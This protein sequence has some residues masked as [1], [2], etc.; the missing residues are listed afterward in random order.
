MSCAFVLSSQR[1]GS[2]LLRLILDTHPEIWSPDEIEMGRLTD[3]LI[4]V[5]E[6]GLGLTRP[7]TLDHVDAPPARDVWVATREIIDG[8][9]NGYTEARKKSIWC[10]KT[11]S[12][13]DHIPVLQSVFPDA[14]YICL[15]RHCLDVTQSCIE[16]WKEGYTEADLARHVTKNPQNLIEAMARAWLEKE[17]AIVALERVPGVRTLRVRYE[18]LVTRPEPVVASIFAFLELDN[19]PDL[20]SRVF[21]TPHYYRHGYGGDPNAIFSTRMYDDRIGLGSRL[22]WPNFLGDAVIREVNAMLQELGYPPIDPAIRHFDVG[23]ARPGGNAVEARAT[24]GA[25]ASA[26]GRRLEDVVAANP[27][28]AAEIGIPIEIDAT[29]EGGGR[30]VLDTADGAAVLRPG[31][32]A[33]VSLI[34]AADDLHQLLDGKLN[35]VIAFSEGK[36]DVRGDPPFESLEKLAR[37]LGADKI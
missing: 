32:G 18:D 30:W 26:L 6:A 21:S 17:H 28:L 29:G 9:M 19:P 36:L 16:A 11:P 34:V 13:C 27:K 33:E 24:A 8:L 14:H 3:A 5:V 12:N 4:S 25:T 23:V 31:G 35:P 22:S 37:L 1:S 20:L 7:V 15:H 10:D 2:T